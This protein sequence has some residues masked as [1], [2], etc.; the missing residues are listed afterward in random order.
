MN[1]HTLIEKLVGKPFEIECS[2]IKVHGMLD[3]HSPLYHGPGMIKSASSGKVSFRMYN[4]IELTEDAQLSLRWFKT[5]GGG[6]E[7]APQVRIFAEDYDG[8]SWTGAWSL[9]K[10]LQS[11]GA[12]S[13]VAG[14]FDQLSTRIPKAETDKLTNV[15]EL[16]YGH[17]LDLPLTKATERLEVQDGKILTRAIWLDRHNVDFR[18]AN[19]SIVERMQTIGRT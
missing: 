11:S 7:P 19:I 8:V 5:E 18:G 14:T 1:V 17:K 15:T 4:Q 2:S 3:H 16:V 12:H 6:L 9:P 13:I 10:T